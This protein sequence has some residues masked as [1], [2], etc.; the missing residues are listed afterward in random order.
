MR[1]II[2][3]ATSPGAAYLGGYSADARR[4]DELL[5][6]TGAIRPH[7]K[8]LLERLGNEAGADV[9]RRGV[10][11]TRRLISENGVTY[12]VY[13]DP[14]GADRPWA[15]DPLPLMISAAEWRQIE[16]GV[17][18]RARVL[19]ALL[20]D[21]YGPQR[22]IAEGVV[23]PELPFGHPNF[24]WPAHGI[25]PT[26]GTWL[27]IYAVDLARA[28]DGRWWVLADRTQSPSGAG[29]ALENR[30]I[31]EQVLPDPIRDLDIRKLRGFFAALRVKLLENVDPGESPLAVVLTPGPFNE[32]YFEH[33]YLARQ[34]GVAL[35]EGTDLTVR[36]DT[37]YLKTLAGLKRV[38]AILRRLDDDFCDPLELR[39]DSAL[40]VPGLL[41]AVRAGRVVLANALGTG[42]L[43]SAAWLGFHPGVAERLLGE[44]LTL[45]SIATWWCGED[46]A[47]EYVLAHLNDLVIRPA[48][49]NQH[50]EPV[51]GRALVGPAREA[52]IARLRARP[53]AYVAQEHLAL[54][55]APVLR[56]TG[57]S[58]FAAKAV[59]IRVYAFATAEGRIVMPG[60]LARVATDA[61]VNAVTTQ[62]GGASKDI[63]VLPDPERPA[64]LPEVTA[65]P[66][67]TTAR[68]DLT[69]SRLV[70]NLYWMGR[71]TV[72]CE[73]RA[74]LLRATLA[75]RVDPQIW[76]YGVRMCQDLDVIAADGDPTTSLNDEGDPHGVVADIRRLNWCASQVRSRLSS[77]CWQA[78]LS[79]QQ[80]L[81]EGVVAREAPRQMLDRLLLSLAALAGFSLDDMTQDAGWRLLRIGRRLERL[82]F[83]ARLLS[84]H[85]AGESAKQHGHVEWLLN[86]CDS[87]RIYRPR[88]VAA[89][90]L[91]PTLDLLI[92]DA[93][94]P[95][96]LAFQARAIA[97]DME[98]LGKILQLET[99]D[100]LSEPIPT[101][102]DSQLRVLEG[103]GPAAAAARLNLAGRLQQLALAA[104]QFSD[105]LS[106]RHF[107]H[108]SLDSQAVAT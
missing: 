74:A 64:P 23:P 10:E 12:N 78:V 89:P 107:S 14:K 1:S 70:E 59:T 54:S 31:I 5:D 6:G 32:T 48:Y 26:G 55:Q 20:A 43:E 40:G 72:R 66:T 104:G 30:E 24:L 88:Y 41:G 29:Y 92:R 22:L 11:L 95:R 106:M 67:R 80:Q 8:V 35:S 38:H 83:V 51:F 47:L 75:V 90:R 96:A 91:G 101:L 25:V 94:H 15:L 19:D 37:V 65:G 102:T 46:P 62:R 52:M 93:E 28:P 69:P 49:P 108:T 58:G 77:G 50:F 3:P 85:L 56:G 16:Q 17:A 103:D 39:S 60:G 87:L 9:T 13:A 18:Q 99:G 79:L 4:Y 2:R 21:L 84:R 44:T 7:W 36:N 27:H 98:R 71:Y 61:S 82:Q 76:R 42:V 68:L 86:V 100:A 33:A 81:H 57:V 34:L 45:P 63:W 73:D 97:G 53:Y 105:R